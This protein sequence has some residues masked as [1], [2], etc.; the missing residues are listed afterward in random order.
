MRI[1]EQC[2]KSTAFKYRTSTIQILNNNTK[3]DVSI[4]FTTNDIV[5]IEL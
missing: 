5:T 4:T 2:L 1:K 3:F